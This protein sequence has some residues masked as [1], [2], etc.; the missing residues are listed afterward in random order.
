M[1]YLDG[2]TLVLS[3]GRTVTVTADAPIRLSRKLN[4][5]RILVFGL[6]YMLPLAVFTSFGYA[7]AATNGHLAGSYIVTTIAMLATASSYA[8][9]VRAYPVAGS[10]YTY[11]RGAF[12][13]HLGFLVGWALLLDY[14]LLPMLSYIL[15]GQYL[16]AVVPAVPQWAWIVGSIVVVTV[17][18]LIGITIVTSVNLALVGAQIL[19]VAVFVIAGLASYAGDQ[20]GAGLLDPFWSATA[21]V[22]HLAAGAAILALAFLGFDAVSTLSE[23]AKEPKRS[24]PRAI[25]LTTLIGGLIFT[26]AAWVAG[27]VFP[28]YKHLSDDTASIDLMVRVGGAVLSGLFTAAFVAGSFASAMASQASVARILYAMGRDRMLPRTVFA[29]VSARFRTPW[30]T[31]LILAALGLLALVVPLDWVFQ[32]INFGALMAFSFVNLSVIKHFLIDRRQR[33]GRAIWLFLVL[34]IIGF[35]MTAWLWTSLAPLAFWIGIPWVV[36]GLIYL[37]GLTRFFTRRPPTMDFSEEDP[38]LA[39]EEEPARTP[40]PLG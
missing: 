35:A 16:S 39:P 13:S 36:V 15:I 25:I 12:G 17:L 8:Q 27:L 22:P 24:I 32:M 6:A 11:T 1:L 31:I 5:G 3:K 4:T 19:F 2:T 38:A 9:L 40:A 33:G 29:R 34:P 30:I 20:R 21:D 7:T 28:D 10:A 26:L 18:N 23:E 37:L 14:L